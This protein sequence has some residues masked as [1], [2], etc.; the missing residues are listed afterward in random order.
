MLISEVINVISYEMNNILHKVPFDGLAEGIIVK[1]IK[2][3]INN[4]FPFYKL[5]LQLELHNNCLVHQNRIATNMRSIVLGK[6]IYL[7]G[8]VSFGLKTDNEGNIIY[9]QASEIDGYEH[10][11]KKKKLRFIKLNLE[12]LLETCLLW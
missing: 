3:Y 4:M 9:R 1:N 6:I 11:Q 10:L 12:E 8:K 2:E 5:T 7:Y